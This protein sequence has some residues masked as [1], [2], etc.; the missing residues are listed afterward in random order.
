[1]MKKLQQFC[2]ASVFAFLMFP[3]LL[4]GAQYYV[5]PT[6]TGSQSGNNWSNA[7]PGSALEA[8]I[9]SMSDGDRVNIG[10]GTYSGLG[11]IYIYTNGSISAIKQIVGVDTGGGLPLFQGTWSE[12][13]PASGENG[14]AFSN[15]SSNWL[16]KDIRMK[17]FLNA[18]TTLSDG[19]ND[20]ITID[21]VDTETTR[22]GFYLTSV[23]NSEFT[24]LDIIRYSKKGLRFEANCS[25][26]IVTNSVA[27]ASD[28]DDNWFN[29]TEPIPMGFFCGDHPDT[30]DITFENCT[31]M[32]NKRN[33]Q[34]GYP[35]GDGFCNEKENYNISYIKC[36]SYNNTDAG[37]DCKGDN[38]L[39]QDCISFNNYRNYRYWDH[40]GYLTNSMSGF[41]YDAGIWVH[42]T[43][44]VEN[45][46]LV[47]NG[48]VVG[49]D[50]SGGTANFSNSIFWQTGTTPSCGSCTY[51]D[52]NFVNPVGIYWNGTPPDAYN[53]QAFPT[54]GYFYQSP[55]AL[56]VISSIS[57]SPTSGNTPLPV[58]FNVTA[59]DPDGTVVA[60]DWDFGDGGT[61][62]QE[63]P[64]YTFNSP[65]TFLV[66][67]TATDNTG[68]EQTATV[69][70]TVSGN[71]PPIVSLVS[72]EGGVRYAAGSSVTLVADAS[73]DDGTVTKVEFYNG[74]TKVGE[75]TSAP[76]E[77]TISSLSAGVTNFSA[78]A[79]DNQNATKT[80]YL[81]VEALSNATTGIIGI[82]TP[83]TID[84]NK[85]N[86]WNSIPTNSLNN[87]TTGSISGSSDL[88]ATWQAAWDE[89]NLYV[90]F[91]VTDDV[92]SSDLGSDFW[93]DD[94]VEVYI[95]VNYDHGTSY[96]SGDA[97]LVFRYNDATVRGNGSWVGANFAQANTASGYAMEIEI[98]WAALG[99]NAQSGMLHGIDFAVGDDDTGGNRE[100]KIA[101]SAT[102]DVG[103]NNPSVFG[104][105]ELTGTG[106]QN[107]NYAYPNGVA[108]NLP[109]R[110]EMENYD[111]GGAGVSYYDSS[112]GNSGGGCRSEDVDFSGS[113][114]CQLGWVTAG[115]WLEYT[116]NVQ[117]AGNYTLDVRFSTPQNSRNFEIVSDKAGATSGNISLTNTGDWNNYATKTVTGV[118]LSA[119]VQ[120]LRFN[121]LT[122]SFNLDYVDF[123][124]ET[125]TVSVT[126]ISVSPSTASVAV[127]ATQALS[128]TISPSNAT[129]QGVSWSSSNTGVATVNSSGVVTGVSTGSATITAT[130]N[131]GSFI[132]NSAITVTAPAPSNLV[133][134]PGFE[135]GSVTS[136]WTKWAGGS[137]TILISTT[138]AN[139]GT[140]SAVLNT[141]SGGGTNLGQV[142]N[143]SPN[144]TYTL[145]AYVKN[146]SSATTFLG[147]KNHGN[148]EASTSYTSTS[149]G[150]AQVTFVTGSSATT[151]E[152]FIWKNASTGTAWVDD[153]SLVVGSSTISVTGISVSPSTVSVLV[154]ATQTL[155]AT[156]APSNATNQGVSWSSNNTSVATVNSSGVVT[157]VSAGTATITAT[158]N[159]GNFTANS[160]ITVTA[161]SGNNLVSNPGF[162]N[163]SVGSP[164]YVW[165]GG[166]SYVAIS[167]SNVNHGT[168]SA[169]CN[170]SGGGGTYLSQVISVSPN[171]SYTLSC[172]IKN[173]TSGITYLGVKN[174]GYPEASTTYTSTAYGQAQ[175]NFTTGSS[176]T[177]AEIFIWKNTGTGS[178]WIDDFS[179]VQTSG[180]RFAGR[181]DA[182]GQSPEIVLYPT[183]AQE[184]IQLK[185]GDRIKND[186][187]YKIMDNSGRMV[188]AGTLLRENPKLDVSTFGK[189]MYF[190]Q[191]NSGSKIHNLRFIKQ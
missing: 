139:Q 46:T 17:K 167:T 112:S 169:E 27:D 42:G 121:L 20:N 25:N 85:D 91:D 176:A 86:L 99:V 131:D 101:W 58:S 2:K 118:A 137:S 138:N 113:G 134:N 63:D 8:T 136:P 39:F 1:M 158:S 190:I 10:S 162:E 87:V 120:T 168:Y 28:G 34:T 108:F 127:G 119:G 115:E 173:S 52:P 117:T 21:N 15:G 171:T 24:N 30:H 13:A 56:P 146:S 55:S 129:N 189:G 123:T 147:V 23:Q 186:L 177:T 36:I 157:G 174:H 90:F 142:I 128:A 183:L 93:N 102:T 32:N 132:A 62:S 150:Q 100:G 104:L 81:D 48:K 97:Q 77:Q 166:T 185:L 164:W 151:A 75:D 103:Y 154:G 179:L 43:L 38:T 148:A 4:I 37:F 31:T 68:Q 76:F 7:L 135:T 96:G 105:G 60:Y 26:N 98:P 47:G 61:S 165:K 125:S 180:S 67:V 110:L 79:I 22:H 155:S 33:N 69:T 109:G 54:K 66:E 116:V 160:T 107:I 73:D 89:T 94:A 83:P 50:V 18:V 84:G 172:A 74:T 53:S 3:Y 141:S 124:L 35:N 80:A 29:F 14:F 71:Y 88:S 145:S 72:P 64:S 188:N 19:V 6:G 45:T 191:I 149:Y 140:Y 12:T 152:I 144:T 106:G 95:D 51:T 122:S 178:A 82:T 182:L 59:S 65:G 9:N 44:N 41:A 70:V 114:N 130:S 126:G 5:T 133:V 92:I 181:E 187:E 57:A 16:L 40:V 161:P 11:T 49:Y 156:I 143:V 170:T 78:I 163:G 184:T 111:T 159:D 175:M 153:F